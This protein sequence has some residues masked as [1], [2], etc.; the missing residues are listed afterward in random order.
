[1]SL[2]DICLS[3]LLKNEPCHAYDTVKPTSGPLND[4]EEMVINF[5]E[6]SVNTAIEDEYKQRIRCIFEWETILCKHASSVSIHEKSVKDREENISVQ[7]IA[8]QLLESRSVNLLCKIC[9]QNDCNIL[10]FP[11]RHLAMCASCLD[12]LFDHG[13]DCCPVCRAVICD[14]TNVYIT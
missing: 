10:I 5:Q 11:C 8:I 14:F 4:F 7:E 12:A 6:L 9:L 3:K 2:A 1:M 13:H